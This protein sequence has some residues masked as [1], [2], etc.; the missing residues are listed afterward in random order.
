MLPSFQPFYG[1]RC[2]QAN[3][4]HRP[5]LVLQGALISPAPA[6]ALY[7]LAAKPKPPQSAPP[8]RVSHPPRSIE[9]S[10][11]TTQAPCS[12]ALGEPRH[13]QP[14]LLSRS[15]SDTSASLRKS[16]LNSTGASTLVSA[17]STRATSDKQ[18][19]GAAVQ[20]GSRSE[21]VHGHLPDKRAQAEASDREW[22]TV[23]PSLS[24]SKASQVLGVA[25]NAEDDR[26]LAPDRGRDEVLGSRTA[27]LGSA[28][29]APL[30]G[31][32]ADMRSEVGKIPDE[33][34]GGAGGASQ[35]F[36]AATHVGQVVDG[37]VE[38]ADRD[39]ETAAMLKVLE[40]FVGGRNSSTCEE[41]EGG[42]ERGGFEVG[43][44]SF[45]IVNFYHLTHVEHPVQ[46]RASPSDL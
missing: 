4:H 28:E 27:S 36:A 15:H 38:E 45:V 22:N 13:P 29:P 42:R 18:S 17:A 33:R 35:G 14:P 16:K 5:P 43:G 19:S 8:S 11:L 10:G 46:V 32:T 6:P 12:T 40:E 20:V 7:H 37:D 21:G 31:G 44:D 39:E 25:V 34:G 1:K 23:G 30:K 41:D 26:S 2:A 24:S 9:N 3:C